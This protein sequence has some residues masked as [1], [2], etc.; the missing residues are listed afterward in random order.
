[1]MGNEVVKIGERFSRLV[2]LE[3]T[4]PAFWHGNKQRMVKCECDCGVVKVIRYAQLKSGDTKSCGCLKK[5]GYLNNWGKPRKENRI[6]HEPLYSVWQGMKQRCSNPDLVGWDV[7]G[8]AGVKVCER[9]ANDYVSFRDW[10]LSNGWRKGLEID[11]DMIPKKLGIPAVLYS[12]EMCSI[13]TRRQNCNARRSNVY[14]NIN[15]IEM[16]L[17]DACRFCGVGD[18]Y[19]IVHQRMKREGLTFEMA[20]IF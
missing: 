6:I 8:G 5:E 3:E 2:V 4:S 10:A 19:K 7:Y 14:L 16:T 15:G 12:P 20:I 13:V 9:W 11:K 18:K 17:A 1:M